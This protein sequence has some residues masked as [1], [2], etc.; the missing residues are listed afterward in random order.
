[1]TTAPPTSPNNAENSENGTESPQ[2]H[3][4]HPTPATRWAALWRWLRDRQNSVLVLVPLLAVAVALQVYNLAGWPQRAESEATYVA[5][6]HRLLGLGEF[7]PLTQPP[8][9]WLHLAGYAALTGAFD[10][11][12]TA[13]LA[14][15]EFMVVVHVAA[16]LLLWL[17][18]RR[19]GMRYWT[20]SGVLLLFAAAP[21]SIEYHRLASP[22]NV[23]VVWLLAAFVLVCDP[24]A[25]LVSFAGSA[26]AFSVA[27]L[28][29]G[30]LLLLLPIGGWLLW[31]ATEHGGRGRALAVSSAIVATA[32]VGYVVTTLLTTGFPT[33][34]GWQAAALA[35]LLG[36]T[37]AAAGQGFTAHTLHLWLGVDPVLPLLGV[38]GAV[39][40]LFSR[41]MRPYAV[42]MLV[43]LLVMALAG[44]RVPGSYVVA[45]LP[46]AALTAAGGGEVAVNHARRIAGLWR[47]STSRRTIFG[48]TAVRL[49]P[50]RTIRQRPL[51]PVVAAI[52]VLLVAVAVPGWT[53]TLRGSLP[54]DADAPLREAKAWLQRNVTPDQRLIVDGTHRLGLPQ[55]GFDS[56]ALTW[57]R[58]LDSAPRAKNPDA[59]DWR[60][61]DLVVETAAMRA[62]AGD[63]APVRQALADSRPLAEFGS[64]EERVTVRRVLP[65][66]TAVAEERR[67]ADLAAR[68][69]VGAQLA[70]TSALELTEAAE[71]ALRA[72]EVDARLLTVLPLLAD[73]H[74]LSIAGF[75]REPVE[76]ADA[77]RRTVRLTAVDGEPAGADANAHLVDGW[78]AT[79][80]EALQPLTVTATEP[81]G[82]LD[83]TYPAPSPT[84]LL[85]EED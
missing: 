38:A 27:V 21:L 32:G 42:G 3:E 70:D 30:A 16:C 31:R 28:T 56:A 24:R 12:A 14:G 7:G 25:R 75:P 10:R 15:R 44:G 65:E 18:A 26:V 55:A 81:G 9:G 73:E 37:G 60:A 77:P 20:T 45:M 36:G 82:E 58:D 35:W 57:Y 1:M 80:P 74:T 33:E 2:P 79:Q 62:P 68:E 48:F 49:L 17:L 59:T 47:P 40:G 72:G 63:A 50:L 29:D 13:V 66:G 23:A 34:D 41:R 11:A 67:A 64:G 78:L 54:T 5:Q 19:T 69:R 61:H 43:L 76:P 71:E 83:I 8:L 84:G 4:S 46:L 85:P 52:G 51:V 22:D 53:A 39:S 6:A